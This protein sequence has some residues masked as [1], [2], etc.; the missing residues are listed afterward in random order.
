M[1]L[2]LLIIHLDHLQRFCHQPEANS[3][4]HG[5]AGQEEHQAGERAGLPVE[6]HAA[7]H[8]RLPDGAA[9]GQPAGPHHAHTDPRPHG[10]QAE[11]PLHRRRCQDV[12]APPG[13]LPRRA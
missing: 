11:E 10:G 3:S 9:G 2:S 6:P 13:R 7:H 4:R 8:R 5:T 12:L 1:R